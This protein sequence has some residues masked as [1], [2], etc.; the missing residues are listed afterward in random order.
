MWRAKYGE[1]TVE[2]V[3]W[4]PLIKEQNEGR[5]LQE[6]IVHE[7]VKE[8]IRANRKDNGR[9][10]TGQVN[11]Q[12][13]IQMNM[14][15]TSWSQ[16][17]ACSTLVWEK[18]CLGLPFHLYVVQMTIKVHLTWLEKTEGK[19]PWQNGQQIKDTAL[20]SRRNRTSDETRSL[21]M[22]VGRRLDAVIASKQIWSIFY[23]NSVLKPFVLAH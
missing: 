15:F 19:I 18:G 22:S 2:V 14:Q 8:W 10:G 13:W 16:S 4:L 23:F 1:S 12:I 3:S 11:Q 9:F 7:Y 20:K 5:S 21:V 17:A 6:E